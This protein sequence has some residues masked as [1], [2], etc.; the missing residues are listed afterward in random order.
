LDATYSPT[1]G[2]IMTSEQRDIFSYTILHFQE[3]ARQNRFP[4]NST[5]EHDVGRCAICHPELLPLDPFVIYLEVVTESVKVRRPRLDESF[6][7]EINKDLALMDSSFRVSGE[8]LLAGER[9]SVQCWSA[10]IRDAITTGLDLLSVHCKTSREFSLDEAEDQGWGELVE[11]KVQ[12]LITYQ[13]N[14]V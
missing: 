11:N 14:N 13:K 2:L 7:D 1:K 8:S 5:V 3:V 10:W 4:E 12:E 9:K 6:V